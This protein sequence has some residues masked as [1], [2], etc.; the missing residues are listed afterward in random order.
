MNAH[1]YGQFKN[2]NL[3][4]IS[5]LEAVVLLYTEAID[6]LK[7]AKQHFLERNNDYKNEIAQ[8]QKIIMG[9]RSII[10]YKEGG[11]IALNLSE[12]YTYFNSRLTVA[13]YGV[14]QAAGIF[15]EAIGLLE[16]LRESW[17]AILP[18]NTAGQAD[19]SQPKVDKL[20]IN[21]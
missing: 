13:S 2:Q 9:L 17:I 1:A 20:D 16:K 21:I 12:L 10:N 5:D 15:S 6:I 19:K 7:K 18:K 4:A 14:R 8:A 11:E 3:M